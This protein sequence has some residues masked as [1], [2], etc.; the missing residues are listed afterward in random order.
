MFDTHFTRHSVALGARF[1][2]IGVSLLSFC[3]ISSLNVLVA[4]ISRTLID[5][6]Y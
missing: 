3:V 4:V 6:M 2:S 5:E 1:G